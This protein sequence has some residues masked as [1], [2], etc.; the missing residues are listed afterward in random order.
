[1]NNTT[2]TLDDVMIMNVS[3]DHLP[4][5]PENYTMLGSEFAPGRV[6]YKA[7]VDEDGED[8]YSIAEYAKVTC[9]SQFMVLFRVR[10]EL[11]LGLCFHCTE[12]V[13]EPS[14]RTK[15][16]VMR[17]YVGPVT[18][19]FCYQPLEL[20][21]KAYGAMARATHDGDCTIT[22]V[23]SNRASGFFDLQVVPEDH[24]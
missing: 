1:M 12:V 16:E 13:G 3:V 5:W 8:V 18:G 2:P 20:T 11:S 23:T 21:R 24:E 14:P 9:K 17:H 6:M 10:R 15:E 4:T 7:G 22:I 19:P